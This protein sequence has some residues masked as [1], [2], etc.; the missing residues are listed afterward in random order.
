MA[1]LRKRQEVAG[2]AA[3]A[4]R[5]RFRAY[6]WDPE[7]DAELRSVETFKYLGRVVANDDCDTPAIRRNLKQARMVW[8]RIQKVIATDTVPPRVAGM[9]Y[10]AVVAAVLLY[11]SETWCL[12]ATARRPLEGFHVEAARRLTGTRPKEVKGEWV[13]PHTAD[14]L[15]AAGL[16]TLE[17]YI[18]K[19]R[20]TI[21]TTIQGRPILEEC[22]RAERLTGTPLRLNWWK[23]RLDYTGEEAKGEK[24]KE[25]G[26]TGGLNSYAPPACSPA[27]TVNPPPPPLPLPLLEQAAGTIPG[28]PSMY[29]EG[30]AWVEW[31]QRRNEARD[32]SLRA[33]QPV[34]HR[35][36]E[37]EATAEEEATSRRFLR[38]GREG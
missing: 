8:G 12:P 26:D 16:Q 36:R 29:L 13:Y 6:A 33:T 5:Q 34:P 31:R 14:V 7:R 1:A 18:D 21:A 35:R 2:Q 4:A 37:V 24:G 28:A 10:Q 22:R 3:K 30:A 15:R 25:A 19:R 27:P 9:F 38:G 17:H 23:Q 20:H 11:G 32:A